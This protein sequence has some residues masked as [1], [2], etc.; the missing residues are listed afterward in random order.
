M[1]ASI[2]SSRIGIYICA[3][4]ENNKALDLIYFLDLLGILAF[5]ISGV[6]VAMDKRLDPFGIFIIAFVTSFG[7]GTLRDIAIGRTPVFWMKDLNYIYMLVISTV[8]GIVFRN[9]LDRWR[10]TLF[11]FDTIGL[12]VYTII[13]VSIG[14]SFGL[15]PIICIALGVSTGSFGGVLRDI[16]CNEIPIIFHKEIYATA[17]LIGGLAYVILHKYEINENVS[18]IVTAMVVMVIRQLAVQYH[19]SLPSIY[20]KSGSRS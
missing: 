13:G 18:K 7:G 11:I 5:A 8:I 9:Y 14:L 3:N 6:L 2:L 19:F 17:S 16:L 1:D 12:G 4:F 10:R 20:P 15:H